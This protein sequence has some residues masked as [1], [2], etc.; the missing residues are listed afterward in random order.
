MRNTLQ[1]IADGSRFPALQHSLG[2]RSWLLCLCLK[3]LSV[4]AFAGQDSQ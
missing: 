4:K 1:K 3:K 2:A